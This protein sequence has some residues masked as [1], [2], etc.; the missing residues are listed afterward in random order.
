ML[1][2][3]TFNARID[4]CQDA[5]SKAR[6]V[7]FPHISLSGGGSQMRAVASVFEAIARRC[8]ENTPDPCTKDINEQLRLIVATR[9]VLGLDWSYKVDCNVHD[10]NQRR[11]TCDQ[12]ATYRDATII[13]IPETQASSIG[14]K[15]ADF[16]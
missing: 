11:T 1:N 9:H 7:I 13:T 10:H 4:H 16:S 3:L 8:S 2:R 15:I 12:T 5:A 6:D 14:G